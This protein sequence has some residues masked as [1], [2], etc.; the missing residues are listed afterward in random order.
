MHLDY[1]NRT[2]EKVFLQPGSARDSLADPNGLRLELLDYHARPKGYSYRI[3]LDRPAYLRLN[4]SHFG[5]LKAR[6]DGKPAPYLASATFDVVMKVPAG[7]HL[8]EIGGG[9][10][11]WR[12]AW[13]FVAWAA[14]ALLAFLAIR[15]PAGPGERTAEK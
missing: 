4:A 15:Y 5:F 12:K 7:E 3:R 8:I 9:W 2:A 11:P 13:L 1:A 14:F 10:D 6:L